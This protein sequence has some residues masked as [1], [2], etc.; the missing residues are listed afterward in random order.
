[1][2]RTLGLP[3]AKASVGVLKKYKIAEIDKTI[4]IMIAVEVII[5]F[6]L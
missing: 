6:I 5:L 4:P 3:S 2:R 1:M